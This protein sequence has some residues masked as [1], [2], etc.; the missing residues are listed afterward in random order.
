MSKCEIAGTG[1]LNGV[2]IAVCCMTM[3]QNQFLLLY[4]YSKWIID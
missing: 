4:S 3:T 1:S 2:K